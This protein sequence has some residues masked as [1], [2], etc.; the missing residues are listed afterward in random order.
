MEVLRR[1]K[2]GFPGLAEHSPRLAP[3]CFR[4]IKVDPSQHALLRSPCQQPLAGFVEKGRQP[5]NFSGRLVRKKA[6]LLQQLCKSPLPAGKQ[7]DRVLLPGKTSEEGAV[8]PGA[9]AHKLR[10]RHGVEPLKDAARRKQRPQQLP[11]LLPAAEGILLRDQQTATHQL[12][13]AA[14]GRLPVQGRAAVP[15]AEQLRFSQRGHQRFQLIRR[16]NKVH[17]F[18]SFTAA[19]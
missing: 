15:H 18:A 14:D 3:M 2:R 11:Q 17:S 10:T 1:Q 4:I 7:A 19:L 12:R 6:L 9:I 5:G 8:P 13:D 16:Q